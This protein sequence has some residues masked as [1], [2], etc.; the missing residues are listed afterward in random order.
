MKHFIGGWAL[1]TL[2]GGV[3]LTK[4]WRG[5]QSTALVDFFLWSG[6]VVGPLVG[7]SAWGLLP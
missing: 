4:L 6:L 5:K 3:I 1:G 7:A 2:I